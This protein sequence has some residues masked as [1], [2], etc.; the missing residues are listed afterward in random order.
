MLSTLLITAVLVGG[1]YGEAH[2][3]NP[4]DQVLNG[5]RV[6][7]TPGIALLLVGLACVVLAARRSRPVPVLV[8]STLAVV[9]YS[10]LGYVN[11]AALLAPTIALYWVTSRVPVRQALTWTGIT[12]VALMAASAGGNPFGPTGGGFYL[13][14]FLVAAAGIGGIAV[15]NRR[16]YLASLAART[17]AEAQRR[18]DEERLRIARELHDIVAHTMATIN[19]QAGVAA[20]LADRPEDP[21]VQ[22]LT[23][24]REV[25]GNGLKELR[26]ILNVLRRAGEGEP[27]DPTPGLDRVG[28]L[29][30]TANLAGL[31]TELTVVGDRGEV[32]PAVDLAAYRIVQEALTNAIRHAGPAAAAVTLTYGPGSL[33]VEISDTGR[34]PSGSATGGHGL[35]GMKERAESVGGTVQTGAGPSRG[36]TVRAQLP[37]LAP[38]SAGTPPLEDVAK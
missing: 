16:A 6:P 10:A 17:E 24:I 8:I 21:A 14:P 5:H 37:R 38:D 19:V 35:V 3:S 23:T 15:A 34:G 18:V 33:L 32:A 31:Q 2:P 29:V 13:V 27:T 1:S 11:G 20:H 25:S 7:H 26:A 30:R 4:R 9:T 28:E 22:A 12:L 36:F